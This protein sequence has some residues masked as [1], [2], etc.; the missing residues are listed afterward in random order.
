MN[1]LPTSPPSQPST[2]CSPSNLNGTCVEKGFICNTVGACVDGTKL[3]CSPSN[4]VNPYGTCSAAA[5][6]GIQT[7]NT[8]GLCIPQK[9]CGNGSGQDPNTGSCTDP[10]ASCTNGQCI[11]PNTCGTG[12]DQSLNGTCTNPMDM[13]NSGVC[14][15]PLPCGNGQGSPPTTSVQGYCTDGQT[16]QTGVCMTVCGTGY[17]QPGQTC[18]GNTC[19][20]QCTQN[21]SGGAY[22]CLSGYSCFNGNCTNACTL[23]GGAYPCQTGYSCLSGSCWPTCTKSEDCNIGPSCTDTG[24]CGT[25]TSP[26][27]NLCVTVPGASTSEANGAEAVCQT[28]PIANTESIGNGMDTSDGRWLA[29]ANYYP[30]TNSNLQPAFPSSAYTTSGY[31]TGGT[32]WTGAC[33]G[34]AG[35]GPERNLFCNAVLSVSGAE[36]G[37]PTGYYYSSSILFPDTVGGLFTVLRYGAAL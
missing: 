23:I 35:E 1:N 8:Q 6:G 26:Q 19:V 15:L 9:P 21:G 11:L 25:S 13:C 27:V 14:G 32:G 17:C 31:P 5:S 2:I 12:P 20:N 33:D 36:S 29:I 30:I 16:C 28:V 4:P 7:C 18:D 34:F 37:Q 3:P 10:T 22:P 24:T